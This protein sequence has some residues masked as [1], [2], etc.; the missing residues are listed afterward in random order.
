MA[1]TKIS[2]DGVKDDAITKAK[3]PADQIEASE[4]AND[5]VDTNAI[6]DDAVTAA[7][8]DVNSVQNA[9]IVTGAVATDKIANDAVTTNKIAN[10]AVTSD[11]LPNSGITFAKITDIPQ[12]RIV[13]RI[14]SGSGVLQELTAANVRSIINVEDGATAG[15]GKILQTVNATTSS[16]VENTS[17]SYYD[18]NLSASITLSAANK[19]LIFVAQALEARQYNATGF[20][21][22][23]LILVRTT[24]GSS[25]NVFAGG[26][27]VVTSGPGSGSYF[28]AS[29]CIASIIAEDSPGVGTHNYKTQIAR[30]VGGGGTAV[31]ANSDGHPA[32]IILMEVAQ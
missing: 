19:V 2:T 16:Q 13:G 8:L 7:K 10:N 5:A 21:V 30:I 11:K 24:S 22:G 15:G 1:L 17:G 9:A 3:I 26:R 6:Q 12:N 14:S 25:T 27:S 32:E 31:R 4:L 20:S 23:R 18:T 28:V 29:G